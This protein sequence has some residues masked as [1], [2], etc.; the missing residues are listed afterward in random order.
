VQ[1]YSHKNKKNKIIRKAWIKENNNP[2]YFAHK[3]LDKKF[4]FLHSKQ[5]TLII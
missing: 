3:N 1:K 5:M 2:S 4:E